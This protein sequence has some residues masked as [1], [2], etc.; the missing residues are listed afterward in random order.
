MDVSG[1]P[2][3]ISGNHLYMAIVIGTDDAIKQTM[4]RIGQNPHMC[5]IR[6]KKTKKKIISQIHFDRKNLLGLCI[7]IERNKTIGECINL[8]KN[9]KNLRRSE[10]ICIFNSQLF[11]L[12][13]SKID[14]FLL[15]HHYTLTEVCFECDSDCRDFAKDNCLSHTNASSTHSIADAVAWG[16]CKKIEPDGT[17]SIDLTSEISKHVN[18]R[19]KRM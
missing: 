9:K 7:K 17:I 6:N 16:N 3:R 4:N 8:N 19:I 18:E 12:L 15:Q 1:N 14:N 11:K 10:L 13:R 5:R 2:G